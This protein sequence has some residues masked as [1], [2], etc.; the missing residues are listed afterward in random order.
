V[1]QTLPEQTILVV[2]DDESMLE[3]L[4]LLLQDEGYRVLL[5][6]SGETALTLMQQEKPDL[7]VSD[8]TMPG[9]DGFDLYEHILGRGEWARIPFI[10]LT[11]RG[12]RADVRKGME[13]GA[14]DYLVKP[15]EPEE[16][17]NAVKVRL[18]R[19]A[20][21][22]AVIDMAAAGLQEQIIRTLTHEF[23]TPLALVVGYTELLEVSGQE[24]NEDDFQ[25]TLQGLH[26]GSERLKGLVEDFLFLSRL[27]TGSIANEIDLRSRETV[28][29]DKAI[30][31]VLEQFESKAAAKRIS[32][33]VAKG[34]PDLIIA[35]GHLHL[36]E[37]M[38]RLVDNAIKFSKEGGGHVSVTTRQEGAYWVMDVADSGIG[39]P[40]EA[41]PWIF[42]AFR[43]VNRDKI[44]QQGSGVG[45][46]IVQGLVEAYGGRVAVQSTPDR[47]STFT[48][49][50]P[51]AG[52]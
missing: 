51:L 42:E 11:A 28:N 48:V 37:I 13:L 4:A 50:L 5:A 10:F 9:M 3:I 2:E 33:Q 1:V 17:L 21:T 32:F 18:E 23:R 44:E 43:Q 22:R 35:I 34:A 12:Q 16:L 36:V 27:N 20:E 38:R 41:L 31:L 45:L 6:S 39:I 30:D 46:T 15:F 52:S 7:I 25:T 49:W 14:D 40:S 29:P 8:V 26:S 19:A 24:M 47:G